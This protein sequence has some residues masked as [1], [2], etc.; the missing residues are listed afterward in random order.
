MSLVL[1]SPGHQTAIAA[2]LLW[3]AYGWHTRYLQRKGLTAIH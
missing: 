3:I 1:P 2:T